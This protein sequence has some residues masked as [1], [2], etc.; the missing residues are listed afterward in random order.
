[1]AQRAVTRQILAGFTVPGLPADLQ[2]QSRE[3]L[4]SVRG[5]KGLQPPSPQIVRVTSGRSHHQY[6]YK[7][8]PRFGKIEDMD[9]KDGMFLSECQLLKCLDPC[10]CGVGPDWELLAK[11]YNVCLVKYRHVFK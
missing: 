7:G 2:P 5:H 3:G 10:G 1:M 6:R 11:H 4:K 8:R 9:K